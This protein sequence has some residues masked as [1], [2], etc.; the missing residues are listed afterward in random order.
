MKEWRRKHRI[1]R[2]HSVLSCT[3]CNWATTILLSADSLCCHVELRFVLAVLYAPPSAVA[4]VNRVCFAMLLFFPYAY[5]KASCL[6]SLKPPISIDVCRVCA[7]R[8]RRR[9]SR[10]V[11]IGTLQSSVCPEPSW[12]LNRSLYQTVSRAYTSGLHRYQK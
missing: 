3:D 8:V 9:H 11:T 6:R 2:E 10:T 1:K 5:C 12:G 7:H 4:L